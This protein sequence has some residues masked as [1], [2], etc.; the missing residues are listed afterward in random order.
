M[1]SFLALL[2]Y[3]LRRI[4][5]WRA[6]RPRPVVS[7]AAMMSREKSKAINETCVCGLWQVDVVLPRDNNLHHEQVPIPPSRH[8]GDRPFI[9]LYGQPRLLS[10]NGKEFEAKKNDENF[11]KTRCDRHHLF[12]FYQ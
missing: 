4:H 6:E 8:C 5:V 11:V 12:D 2:Y 9:C 7:A 1:G 10:T 3:R